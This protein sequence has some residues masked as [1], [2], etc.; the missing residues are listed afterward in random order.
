MLKK[1]C[2]TFDETYEKDTALVRTPFRWVMLLLLL[3]GIFFLFP[4]SANN[5]F[6]DVANNLGIMIIAV[7]GLQILVGFCG[8]ISLG[9]AAFMG[10]GAYISAMISFHFGWS[11]WIAM[12][13][14]AFFSGL[15]GVV[16]GLPALKIRGFYIAVSTL[17]AHYIILWVI[18]HGGK[19]TQGTSGLPAH[20]IQ[21]GN[22]T[23]NNEIRMFYLIMIFV[24]AVIFLV[25]NMM[26]TKTGRAFLAVRDSDLAA[27]FMGVNV[28]RTKVLAFSM[29]SVCAG[30]SGSL[31]AHYQGI[32]TV[33]HFTLSDSIWMLGML[34]IGGPTITGAILGTIFLKILS[35]VVL[36]MAPWIGGI[37][38]AFSGSSVAGFTQIFFGI[39]ILLFLVFEPRGLAH[40]WQIFLTTFRLWPFKTP[41]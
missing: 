1:P 29:A 31:M 3:G 24:I 33:E 21:I 13:C 16:V 34:I 10:V 38:T 4:L 23:F 30:I 19:L 22:F 26:R 2:G 27:E 40:R 41:L 8:Q 12:P 36:F 7:I 17:A 5:Y 39:V 14:A 20:E 37:F 25:N 32:V 6:L 28:F 11:F 18:L 15:L 9:H 35:Q